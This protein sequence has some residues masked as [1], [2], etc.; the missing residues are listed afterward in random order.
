MEWLW[1]RRIEWIRRY[2]VKFNPKIGDST[3]CT[4]C[5][6]VSCKRGLM[7]WFWSYVHRCR[8]LEGWT[9]LSFWN[10]TTRCENN[11]YSWRAT[12]AKHATNTRSCNLPLWWINTPML[13]KLHSLVTPSSNIRS[14]IQTKCRHCWAHL[15]ITQSVFWC[16][17]SCSGYFLA[18]ISVNSPRK[19]FIC[20]I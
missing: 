4:F 12:S 1:K 17:A 2:I 13:T 9:L 5:I 20:I 19:L 6:R 14:F 11:G 10:Q 15:D 18:E 3:K 8:H 16:S 7:L